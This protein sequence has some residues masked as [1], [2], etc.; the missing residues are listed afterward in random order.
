MRK[1]LNLA[2]IAA[3]ALAALAVGLGAQS[4][5]DRPQAPSVATR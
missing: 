3:S 1:T 4:A 5:V 2:L